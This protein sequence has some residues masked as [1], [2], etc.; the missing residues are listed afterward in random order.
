M[1]RGW[2][3]KQAIKRVNLIY[4]YMDLCMCLVTVLGTDILMNVHLYIIIHRI[5]LN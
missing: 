3:N 1:C 5:N 4:I 2:K